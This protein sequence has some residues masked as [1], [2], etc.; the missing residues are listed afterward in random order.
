MPVYSIQYTKLPVRLKSLAF[1]Q[2]RFFVN[3]NLPEWSSMTSDQVE[4]INRNIEGAVN[5]GRYLILKTHRMTDLV[6]KHIMFSLESILRKTEHERLIH[7]L[8][9]VLKEL[10]INGCKANQK[11]IFFEEQGLDLN[12]VS[13]YQ[14]GME[15][16]KQAFSEK[17]AL[18]YGKKARQRGLYCMID[19]EFDQDGIRVEV[20]NNTAIIPA[21][22]RLMREKLK[23]AMGYNDIAEFYMDQAM[24][25]E[26][27]GAGLGLALIII[28]L[29]GEGIDPSYFRILI[30][31]EKT[32]ARLEIPFSDRFR[33]KR[34]GDARSIG[35]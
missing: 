29:K 11:R 10:V 31:G 12:D 18:E 33:S 9:T 4:R 2:G 15:L 23:K 35:D 8:Y 6:E 5:Q 28:L 30:Q 17:M 26:N 25:G 21:E 20:I 19:F 14:K 22:E 24:S 3:L 13:Q 1:F 7:T 27:E 32:I 34:E 16:Y